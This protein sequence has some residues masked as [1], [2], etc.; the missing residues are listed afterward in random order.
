M[1][2]TATRAPAP[3]ADILEVASLIQRCRRCAL[4]WYRDE[5]V[6]A[7]GGLTAEQMVERGE[8]DK[9]LVFL[10]SIACGHRG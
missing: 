3:D 9:V 6:T 4:E 5:A 7:F 10:F 1:K 8:G 2:T